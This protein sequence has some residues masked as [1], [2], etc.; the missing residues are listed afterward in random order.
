[1]RERNIKLNVY[2]NKK[3]KEMLDKKVKK[4][5]LSISTL[6]RFL[7]EGYEPKEKPPR[8]FYDSIDS[9]RKIGNVLNQ[10]AMRTHYLGYVEDERFLRQTLNKL[11]DMI[12]SIKEY[13]LLP[14]KID[15]DNAN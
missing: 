11:N 3:E 1:M 14:N 5:G 4:T 9:V 15:K 13:Y 6:I 2:L 7:I 10:I 12:V 8:D